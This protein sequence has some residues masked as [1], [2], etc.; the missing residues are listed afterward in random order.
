MRLVRILLYKSLKK[1]HLKYK[2]RAKEERVKQRDMTTEGKFGPDHD[3]G[4]AGLNNK[5]NILLE[6][7][8]LDN[9]KVC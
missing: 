7:L 4:T 6:K 2:E 3:R 5:D 8:V 9:K 1:L